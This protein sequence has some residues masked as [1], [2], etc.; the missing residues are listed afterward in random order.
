MVKMWREAEF[1]F[2]WLEMSLGIHNF[3]AGAG[4]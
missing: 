4:K 2:E 1:T 3:P